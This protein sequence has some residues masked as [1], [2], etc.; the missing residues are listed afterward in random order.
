MLDES[1]ATYKL[2]NNQKSVIGMIQTDLFTEEVIKKLE[3]LADTIIKVIT[4]QGHNSPLGATVEM[5]C[6]QH[7]GKVTRDKFTFEIVGLGLACRFTKVHPPSQALTDS[8]ASEALPTSSFNLNMTA[9][10]RSAKDSLVLPYMRVM[11]DDTKE[12]PKVLADD[13][14]D[15]DP[16]DDLDF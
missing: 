16:D 8:S 15:E 7:G 10:Q 6:R 11:Q 5:I 14:D 13:F 3:Y 12:S 1:T 9:E 4:S 2:L